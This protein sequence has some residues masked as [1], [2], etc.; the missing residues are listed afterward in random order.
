MLVQHFTV[1]LSE[2]TGL[3][4]I[5]WFLPDSF[6]KNAAGGAPYF[7]LTP[8]SL[9]QQK[10]YPNIQNYRVLG[11]CPSSGILET[12]KYSV[13]EIGYVSVLR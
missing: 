8:S 13:S 5:T 10:L 7:H 11:L 12:R 6:K 2:S 1:S 4:D 3:R 9:T